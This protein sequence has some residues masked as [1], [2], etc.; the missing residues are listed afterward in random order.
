MTPDADREGILSAARDYIEGWLDGDAERMGGCLH[1]ALVK[2]EVE[3]TEA[4][5]VVDTMSRDDMIAATATGY[6]TKHER[7]Y[8]MEILDAYGDMATVR[9]LSSRF[10]DHVQVAR[11]EDRWR[12]VNVLWQP[13]V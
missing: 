10:M 12:L 13:R 3:V 4:G 7:P 8:E 2:R 9:I 5:R 11:F 6:G 1:P